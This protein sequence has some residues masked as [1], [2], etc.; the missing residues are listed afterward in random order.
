[1]LRHLPAAVLAGLAPLP[2]KTL[3]LSTRRCLTVT[4]YG[5]GSAFE[6]I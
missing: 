3:L 4:V 5:Q 2:C 6:G 1:M